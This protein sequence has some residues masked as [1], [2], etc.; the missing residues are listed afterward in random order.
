MRCLILWHYL[1][2]QTKEVVNASATVFEG[3]ADDL[4]KRISQQFEEN[5]PGQKDSKKSDTTMA[6]PFQIIRLAP[7]D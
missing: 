2:R 6:V 7:T 1:D 5:R 3:T 4:Q